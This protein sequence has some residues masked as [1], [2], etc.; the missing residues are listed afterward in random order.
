MTGL[1]TLGRL[2]LRQGGAALA[3]ADRAGARQAFRAALRFD[4]AQSD[5]AS[6]LAALANEDAQWQSGEALAREALATAPEHVAANTNL[7]NAL[8]AQGQH[9]A[10]TSAFRAALAADPTAG[11]AWTGLG[12][13]LQAQG[14]MQAAITALRAAVQATP[15][16]P[17]AHLNLSHAL[18]AAG[19]LREG[20][21][22]ME[23]RTARR[24]PLPGVPWRGEPLY[25]RRLL[26]HE[27]GGFGDMLQFARYIPLIIQRGGQVI[28]RSHA[29]L[30][31]LFAALP[32]VAVVDAAD[33]LPPHDLHCNLMSLPKLL[34]TTLATIPPPLPLRV[35]A[36]RVAAWRHRIASGTRRVV[37]LVWA[38]APRGNQPALAAMDARRSLHLAALAPLGGVPD[39]V[40][41]NL[42]HGAVSTQIASS[43]LTIFDAMP[44]M[45][46]FA[47]TATLTA[48]CDLV[49]SADTA[50]AH[51]AGSLGVPIWLL[52]RY[53]GCW[54]WLKD[55]D[56]TPWYPGMRL[57]RQT[58]PGD[59]E[60]VVAE[61]ASSLSDM[62]DLAA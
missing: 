17:I 21:A 39:I 37:G 12:L 28:L 24:I 31:R 55:R 35:D 15:A 22:E 7:G 18:L 19:Q 6:N 29:P 11:D 26:L 10:A 56:D 51:L 16:C 52:D 3:Q 9:I 23:W 57:F 49:I 61:M 1:A 2:R 30:H 25:G 13:A 33:P 58:A 20:W 32:G 45:T 62:A 47:D 46:D 27:E 60:N 42:Q 8:H 48:A 50:M 14:L 38:G 44:E 53:D 41:I 40:L 54:R 43:G 5:A 36:D 59:W 4:P 34:G